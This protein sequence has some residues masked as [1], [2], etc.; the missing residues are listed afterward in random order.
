MQLRTASSLPAPTFVPLTCPL[1]AP[2]ARRF[3]S[4]GEEDGYDRGMH[5][6]SASP[7]G[8]RAS[9]KLSPAGSGEKAQ[10]STAT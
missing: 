9:T 6:V 3:S 1:A 5:K 2:R 4:G 10:P 8:H 7:A